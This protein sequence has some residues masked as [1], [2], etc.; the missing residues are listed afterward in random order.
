MRIRRF[1]IALGVTMSV[2]AAAGAADRLEKLQNTTPEERA[3]AQTAIMK[4]KLD[5]TPEQRGKVADLNLKYAKKMEP[6]I[7]GSGGRFRKMRQFKEISEQKDAELKQVLSPAQ[8]E[9]Y[10]ASKEEMRDRFEK[11]LAEKAGDK[12]R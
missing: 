9:K 6:V 3:T 12:R 5:L 8:F 10:L 11:E 4:S 1:A 7:K 2:A